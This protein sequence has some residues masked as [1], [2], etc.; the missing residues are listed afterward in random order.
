[1]KVL[2]VDDSAFMRKMLKDIFL[3]IKGVKVFEAE[4]SKMAIEKYKQEKPDIVTMDITLPDQDGLITTK[5][6]LEYDENAIIIMCSA[7]G[8][9]S[10]VIEAIMIGAK[11]FITKPFK[12]ETIISIIKKYYK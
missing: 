10:F 2:I 11:D 4:N 9:Q 6:I 3:S 7:M 5:I 8:H 1:M 12:R